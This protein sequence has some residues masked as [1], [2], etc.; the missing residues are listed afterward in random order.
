MSVVR[1]TKPWRTWIRWLL[2]LSVFLL[3]GIAATV[4]LLVFQGRATAR[5]F[6]QAI[7]WAK[8]NCPAPGTYPDLSLPAELR[9]LSA[10]GHANGIVLPDGRIVLLLKTSLGWHHNW[11][12]VI[13]SSHPLKPGEI[14]VDAY[15]RQRITIPGVEEHH[16]TKKVSERFYKVAFDL[17]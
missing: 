15:S 17:G 3:L 12:G 7:T 2:I 11:K 4:A 8:I 10:D 14:G 13:Y 16:V 1:T 9:H 5:D 6:E